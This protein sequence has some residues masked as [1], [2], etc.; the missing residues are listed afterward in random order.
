MAK[1]ESTSTAQQGQSSVAKTHPHAATIAHLE[2]RKKELEAKRDRI[3]EVKTCGNHDMD[4]ARERNKRML[5][6]VN[7]ELKK[8]NS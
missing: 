4:E 3:K 8:L 5:A 7:A 6:E 1:A 2:F